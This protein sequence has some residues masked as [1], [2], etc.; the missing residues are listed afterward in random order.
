[1][2]AYFLSE[3]ELPS[4][5]HQDMVR[6]RGRGGGTGKGR[7][8]AGGSWVLR[9]TSDVLKSRNIVTWT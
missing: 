4:A 5:R 9:Q 7:I 8:F 2:P 3:L 6:G 1:M